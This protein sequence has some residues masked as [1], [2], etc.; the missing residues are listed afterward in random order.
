MSTARP[1][2]R[3]GDIDLVHCNWPWR[4]TGSPNVLVNGRPWSC[5]LDFNA[6]HAAPA[7][8]KCYVHLRPITLGSITV[9]IN[10]RGAGRMA[11]DIHGCTWTFTGSHNV[12]AGG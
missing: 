9:R 10:G 7:A 8:P 6:P 11:D 5:Q 3:I 2:T 4:M 12:M 1:A